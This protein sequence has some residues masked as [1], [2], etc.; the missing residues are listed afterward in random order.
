[1]Q[2]ALGVWL[3]HLLEPGAG[4]A[5]QLKPVHGGPSKRHALQNFACIATYEDVQNWLELLADGV[6]DACEDTCVLNAESPE[7]RNKIQPQRSHTAG[8]M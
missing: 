3:S 5:N 4:H 2:L 1:M 7:D 6:R 8:H